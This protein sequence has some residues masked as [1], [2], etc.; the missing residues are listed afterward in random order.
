MYSEG[1]PRP[2]DPATCS[3]ASSD[4]ENMG[5]AQQKGKK[6]KDAT[7]KTYKMIDIWLKEIATNS[8][9]K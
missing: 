4:R 7:F 1:Q 6:E 3:K 9:N 8:I 5:K 2:V